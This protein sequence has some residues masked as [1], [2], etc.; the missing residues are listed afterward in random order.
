[1]LRTAFLGIL[2]L[3]FCLLPGLQAAQPMIGET[4]PAFRLASLEGPT[5]AL[6]DLRGKFVVIR[7]WRW[8]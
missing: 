3:A 7:C 4:A 1:M 6:A 2:P 5:V 8:T